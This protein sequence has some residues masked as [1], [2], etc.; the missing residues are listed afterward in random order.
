MEFQDLDQ[1]LEHTCSRIDL[2]ESYKN[3]SYEPLVLSLYK[4]IMEDF[5]DNLKQLKL[6]VNHKLE[7]KQIKY[8]MRK[9]KRLRKQSWKL[10][11]IEIREDYKSNDID[12]YDF[13]Y[14]GLGHKIKSYNLFDKDKKP[15]Y[16]SRN[17]S[18]WFKFKSF[19]KRK[20]DDYKKDK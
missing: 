9:T 6:V 17:P 14:L 4:S 3:T 11:F 5:K 7:Y 19:I 18:I 15:K 20:I 13:N 16:L 1:L 8:M 2:I 12:M 10:S